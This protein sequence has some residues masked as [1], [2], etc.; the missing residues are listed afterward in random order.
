VETLGGE[1]E[2]SAHQVEDRRPGIEAHH[3]DEA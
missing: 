1:N 2:R 3:F